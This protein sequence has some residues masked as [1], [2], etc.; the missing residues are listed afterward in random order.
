MQAFSRRHGVL[1]RKSAALA[2]GAVLVALVAAADSTA[3]PSHVTK[4]Q[5]GTAYFAE[6]PQATPNYIFPFMGFQFFSVTNIPQFQQLMYRP[7]YWFGTGGQPTLNSSLSLAQNPVY[8]NNGTEV[9]MKLKPYKF[10]NG[11]K[12]TA[13]DVVFWLNID[14]V[15]RYNWAGY[16]PGAMPDDLSSVTAPNS[17]TVVAE[18]DGHGQLAL[19]HLQRA[20][21][22]HPLPDGV[23]RRRDRPEVR[24]PGLRHLGLLQGDGEDR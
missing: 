19:V 4:V 1:R 14:K 10:S 3:T 7:L 8:S 17:T 9:T 6:G 21:A 22:D 2:A 15:E 16:T 24:Q 13:Q 18:D 23:G 12:L 11:E 5:G 20:L